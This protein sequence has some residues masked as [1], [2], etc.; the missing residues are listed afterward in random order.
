MREAALLRGSHRISHYNSNASLPPFLSVDL[1]RGNQR[2]GGLGWARLE[3]R[4]FGDEATAV[5]SEPASALH[6]ASFPHL[7]FSLQ[8]NVAFPGRRVATPR[9]VSLSFPGPL[10]FPW[11][12][13]GFRARLAASRESLAPSLVMHP[14]RLTRPLALAA[15]RSPGIC[16]HFQGPVN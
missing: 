4:D 8:P 13:P 5:W 7:P 16:G 3:I 12:L 15:G 11:R 2:F 9:E 1:G 14:R 6:P 10:S